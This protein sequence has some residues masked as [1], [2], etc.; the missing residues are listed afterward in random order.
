MTNIRM[1]FRS[2]WMLAGV[3]CEIL[4]FIAAVGNWFAGSCHSVAVAA[5]RRSDAGNIGS[6][7][8]V[9]GRV[10]WDYHGRGLNGRQQEEVNDTV[11]SS[12]LTQTQ[13]EEVEQIT[14]S[15]GL[16]T[17]SGINEKP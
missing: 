10:A 8:M 15:S 7:P 16:G 9:A 17:R 14:E 6:G 4:A 11:S 1:I 12:G 13:R 5:K 2:K 3:L